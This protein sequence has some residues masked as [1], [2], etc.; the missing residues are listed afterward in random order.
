MNNCRGRSFFVVSAWIFIFALFSHFVAHGEETRPNVLYIFPDQFRQ[1]ATGFWRNAEYAQARRTL[2]D[3]VHTPNIDRLADEG[4]VFTQATSTFPICS[5]YRA[6][7]LSGMYPATN[8]VCQNCRSGSPIGLKEGVESLTN[9]L[10]QAG[11]DTAYVGKTHWIR[12]DPVFDAQG[13]YQ[14]AGSPKGGRYANAFDTYIPPGANRLGNRF[15]FQAIR[16]NHKAAWSYS[17]EP[18]LV[19]GKRDGEVHKLDRYTPEVEADV[20]IGYLRN[21]NGERDSDKPFSILWSP[22]APHTPYSSVNDCEKDIY[23]EFYRDLPLE[24]LLNRPNAQAF[25][26]REN[27]AKMRMSASVY[28]SNVSGVDRQIGRVLDALEE[29]GELDN[30]LIIFTSDHGEMMGSLGHMTKGKIYEESFLVPLLIRYPRGIPHRLENLMI[31]PV[32]MMPTILGI[33]GLEERIPA[34]VEGTNYAEGLRSGD[35]SATPKPVSAFFAFMGHKP[36]EGRRGVRTEK[37]AYQVFFDGTTEL[38]NLHDDPYQMHPLALDEIPTQDVQMLQSELGRWLQKSN[39]PWA[40]QRQCANFIL[41]DIS[42]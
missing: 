11:Y 40:R 22:N 33:L 26:N 21:A 29:I 31:S 15:W 5:P 23:D 18:R 8:H 27:S 6:M 10:A 38:F 34:S 28:F 14:G 17:S 1:A 30:T 37:Y 41:Y 36:V 25:L 42:H 12:T 19:G 16:D 13:N 2:S 4:M 35:F 32:D 3:P 20:I 24:K 39:D 9:V 7:L